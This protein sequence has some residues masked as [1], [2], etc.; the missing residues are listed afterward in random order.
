MVKVTIIYLEEDEDRVK[1]SV[2]SIGE[3]GI[4]LDLCDDIMEELAQHSCITMLN[5]SVFTRPH[6]VLQ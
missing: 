5:D 4:S 6:D 3:T 2:E 1:V